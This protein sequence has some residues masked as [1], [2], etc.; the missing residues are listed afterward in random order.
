LGEKIMPDGP[1]IIVTGPTA[2]GKSALALDIA[3]S[4]DGVIINADSMQVYRELRVLTARPDLAT[5]REVPHRLYGVLPGAERCSAGR[6]RV[7]AL[8]EISAAH[9]EG[10]LPIVT[11]GT[12]L[13]LRALVE[14]LDPVPEIPEA[15]RTAARTLHDRLGA[16]DFHA[17]LATR[18]PQMA[19]RLHPND[20]QRLVR[21]WEV[22]EATGRSLADWQADGA[23]A[24]SA[25]A[26]AHRRLWIL[27][28]PPREALYAA[29][30]ARFRVM[31][32][33]GALDEVRALLAL[34]LDTSLPIMRALGVPEL[35]AHLEGR[36]ALEAAVTQAQQSTRKYAKRQET[37]LR[38]QLPSA[39][40][41]AALRIEQHLESLPDDIFAK[42]RQFVLTT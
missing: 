6:W 29:C 14:G 1:V 34:G 30:D 36:L 23:Q 33:Q 39:K 35:A 19:A 20:R 40:R 21:A 28:Q 18:D 25:G 8:A 15:T 5:M 26:L 7:M 38:T 42:I 27:C 41:M 13:Y 11:G 10:K 22:V 3:R 37:W 9:A 12:G 31:M 2:S 32:G 4:F 17:A 24:G 16:Q